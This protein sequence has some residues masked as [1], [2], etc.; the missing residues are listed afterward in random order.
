MFLVQLVLGGH[1]CAE[2]LS[3]A[4]LRGA[5]AGDGGGG[6]SIYPG[7]SWCSRPGEGGW[8]HGQTNDV[9]GI[10]SVMVS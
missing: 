4:H 5:W 2:Q 10:A 1:P 8:S 9:Q 3:S 7:C 6:E